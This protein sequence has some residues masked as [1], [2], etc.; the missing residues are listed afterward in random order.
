[1]SFGGFV[2]NEG[3]SVLGTGLTITSTA[4]ASSAAGTYSLMPSGAVGANYSI[5]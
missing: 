3:P 5:T 2:N 4:T 1:M